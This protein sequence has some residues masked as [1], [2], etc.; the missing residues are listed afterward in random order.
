[1]EHKKNT[2]IHTALKAYR[3][4]HWNEFK[5]PKPIKGRYDISDNKLEK[6]K[7]A[8]RCW[9]RQTEIAEK[10]SG[11]EEFLSKQDLRFSTPADF[12]KQASLSLS[13]GGDLMAVDIITPENTPHLFDDIRDFYFDADITCA[14]LESTVYETAP[15]GR[16]SAA[17]SE[18]ARMNTSEAMLD[19]FI[20]GGLGIN[21]FST[22]N[23]HSFDYGEEGLLAT[24]DVL[25]KKQCFH[26]G[27]NRTPEQQEDV[28]IIEKNGIKIAFLAYTFDLNGHKCE[29]KHLVNEV[30]FNDEVVDISLIK[31]HIKKA[32]EKNA[33]LI[34]ASCHWGWEFEM[35]PHKAI[36]DVAHLL[37]DEGVD[38]I[39][40]G[41]PHVGQPMERYESVQ[42]KDKRQCLIIYSLGNFATYQPL[43]RNSKLTYAVRLQIEKGIS[44]G[45]SQTYVSELKILPIYIQSGD[46]GDG[47]NDFRLVQFEKLLS[48]PDKY[49][50]TKEERDDL[51]RLDKK[52]LKEIILPRTWKEHNLIW[53]EK[54]R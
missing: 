36:I 1:M 30:R 28:L 53:Q 19:K 25:E 46:K 33:D 38:I 9:I 47:T 31:R 7:W 4:L 27:I 37:A 2:L 21:Y 41:H 45:V 22:A 48:N 12:I 3:L 49:I 40:G 8:Y 20:D 14:N 23:N 32:K 39:L 11:I 29:K 13:A 24:L 10:D 44:T 6:M 5:Y 51:P 17:V 16:N 26:S 35:Y 52:V 54:N 50:L 43:S 15:V 34:I 18:A 42:G